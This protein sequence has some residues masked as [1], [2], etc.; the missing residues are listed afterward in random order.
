MPTLYHYTDKD[1]ARGIKKKQKKYASTNT[2][3]DAASGEGVYFTKMHPAYHS[4]EEITRNDWNQGLN[5]SIRP[6]LKY[7]VMVK[8]SKRE[9]VNCSKNGRS[10]FLYEGNVK[11]RGRKYEIKKTEDYILESESEV[12]SDSSSSSSE[13]LDSDFSSSNLETLRLRLG[14][15]FFYI[16]LLVTV[17]FSLFLFT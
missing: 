9:V 8:F 11:L 4:E 14:L 1:S 15:N 12:D 16:H 17:K 7:C 10:I 2:E 6:F 5:S 13:K 3:T